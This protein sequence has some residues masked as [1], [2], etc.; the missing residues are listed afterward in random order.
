MIEASQ[1]GIEITIEHTESGD[2]TGIVLNRNQAQAVR[3][4]IAKADHQL[5]VA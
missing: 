5:S 1:E 3:N 4:A 2:S